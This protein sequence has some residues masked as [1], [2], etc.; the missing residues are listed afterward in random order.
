MHLELARHYP[1][2]EDVRLLSFS[3]GRQLTPAQALASPCTSVVA[4][5]LTDGMRCMYVGGTNIL[6]IELIT[7]PI[8]LLPN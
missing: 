7:H 4:C 2:V 5:R 6:F 1:E 3:G 8:I